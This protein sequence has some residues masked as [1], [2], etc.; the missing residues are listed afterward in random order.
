MRTLQRGSA[1]IVATIVV[2]IIAVIGVGMVRFTQRETAAATAG[3]RGDALSAC[4]EAARRLLE[5]RFHALGAHPTS[6]E[7]LDVRMD[8]PAGRLRAVGG[9][10]DG[11]PSQP[12][13]TVKQVEPL[14]PTA[15]QMPKPSRDLSNV[16]FKYQF[17][18]QPLK[19][20]VHCQEGDLSSPTSGR[21]MEIE[22]GINFGL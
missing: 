10:I 16:I 1:L 4:A 8:G 12:V 22:Y 15:V 17:G 20:M 6:I 14:P 13:V 11:D 2:L 3:L 9:H 18:G 7:V 21:Q 19:V 5:S